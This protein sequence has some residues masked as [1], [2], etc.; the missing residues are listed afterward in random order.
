MPLP[1]PSSRQFFLRNTRAQ[2]IDDAVEGLLIT[3]TR[4]STSGEGL[5][6]GIS[7]SMRFHS[8][9]GISLRR[10]MPAMMPP[11][12]QNSE[13]LLAALKSVAHC[14]HRRYLRRLLIDSPDVSKRG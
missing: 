5:T 1:Q 6:C 4:S 9:T 10:V 11:V 14:R 3:D 2:H 12:R 13:V 8:A 7:D